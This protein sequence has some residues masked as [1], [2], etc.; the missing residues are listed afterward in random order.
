MTK[1]TIYVR[2]FYG[3]VLGKID[4]DEHGDKIVRDFYGKP[5]GRYD[6]RFDVT[7]DFYGRIV[8][9]GDQIYADTN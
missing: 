8:A 7:R 4:V 1:E 5:L 2:N 3:Q 6:K 9:R